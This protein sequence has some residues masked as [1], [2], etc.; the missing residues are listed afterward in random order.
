MCC[1][2]YTWNCVLFQGLRM[3]C[4]VVGIIYQIMYCCKVYPWDILLPVLLMRCVVT[5]LLL[6]THLMSNTGNKISHG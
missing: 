2:D 5:E 3:R 1:G 4:V 6:Q